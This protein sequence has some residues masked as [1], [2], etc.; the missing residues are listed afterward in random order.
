MADWVITLVRYGV[1]L[2]KRL[3]HGRVDEILEVD[4]FPSDLLADLSH[5]TIT[6]Q[7]SFRFAL[8]IQTG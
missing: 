3:A 7:R 1:L 5:T 6:G 4:P 2:K 8:L